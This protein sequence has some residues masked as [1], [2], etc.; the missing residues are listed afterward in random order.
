MRKRSKIVK[1][2]KRKKEAKREREPTRK[3]VQRVRDTKQANKR[4]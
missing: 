1:G 4:E 3:R 2:G